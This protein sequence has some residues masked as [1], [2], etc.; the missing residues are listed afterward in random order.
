[1]PT[2]PIS[3]IPNVTA[4]RTGDRSRGGLEAAAAG[5]PRPGFLGAASE[6]SAGC[7]RIAGG[8]GLSVPAVSP[9]RAVRELRAPEPPLCP[10]SRSPDPGPARGERGRRAGGPHLTHLAGEQRRAR[11]LPAG[12]PAE[13]ALPVVAIAA[14]IPALAP[15]SGSRGLRPRHGPAPAPLREERPPRQPRPPGGA[16]PRELHLFI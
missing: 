5:L 6:A 15:L 12:D 10:L 16:G 11:L 2:R 3:M 13:H 7:A 14:A 9:A 1:M 4:D 8:A